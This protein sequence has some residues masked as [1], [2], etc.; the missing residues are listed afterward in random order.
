[1]PPVPIP[2]TIFSVQRLAAGESGR[3]VRRQVMVKTLGKDTLTETH[4][5][6]IAG[7]ARVRMRSRD[8]AVMSVGFN[9]RSHAC[10]GGWQ[11]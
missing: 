9:P 10:F 11:L 8:G 3:H 6:G 4:H 5:R 1:M 2:H 7:L